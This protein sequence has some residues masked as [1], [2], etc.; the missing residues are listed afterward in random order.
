MVLIALT[1]WDQEEDSGRSRDAGFDEHLYKPVHP[2]ALMRLLAE[3][4][5]AKT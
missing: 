3:L 1:G 2:N 5:K 4:P